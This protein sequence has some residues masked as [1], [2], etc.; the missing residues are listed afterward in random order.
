MF[1]KSPPS[2]KFLPFLECLITLSAMPLRIHFV[3]GGLFHRPPHLNLSL[4]KSIGSAAPTWTL[5]APAGTVSSS[6]PFSPGLLG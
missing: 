2:L 4:R 1:L 6:L 3:L 5:T